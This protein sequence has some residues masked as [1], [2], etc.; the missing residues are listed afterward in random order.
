MSLV[1]SGVTAGVA[2]GSAVGVAVGSAVGVAVGAAVGVAVRLE[3]ADA[4][5]AGAGVVTPA[6]GPAA[7]AVGP[8]VV[9]GPTETQPTTSSA[10]AANESSDFDKWVL[11]IGRDPT[12]SPRER[13][14]R[15]PRSGDEDEAARPIAPAAARNAVARAPDI[16][17]QAGRDLNR[18]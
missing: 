3:V 6:V 15:S 5:V 11:L 13:L 14:A 7:V 9:D 18:D 17:V 8:A 1:G 16:G 2:L 12:K 4:G 10:M